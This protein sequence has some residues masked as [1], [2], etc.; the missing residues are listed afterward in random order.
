MT[1]KRYAVAVLAVALAGGCS[2]KSSILG[3]GDKATEAYASALI[4]DKASIASGEMAKYKITNRTGK[5]DLQ[6]RRDSYANDFIDVDYVGAP[7]PILETLATRY[8]YTYVEV[9][10]HNNILVNL[11]YKALP[12]PEV[13]S[14]IASQVQP[15]AKLDV[16]N[17]NHAFRLIYQR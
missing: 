6:A 17:K 2:F 7:A 4:A 14:L 15:L 8:G 9:G 16:D 10:R 1:A 3:N 12:A 11:K 5:D 13:L